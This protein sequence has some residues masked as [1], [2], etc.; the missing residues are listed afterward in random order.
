[1]A[2]GVAVVVAQLLVAALAAQ[3]LHPEEFGAYATL[4][5]WS[6]TLQPFYVLGALSI[7]PLWLGQHRGSRQ[8]IRLLFGLT[9]SVGV[10]LLLVAWMAPTGVLRML[11]GHSAFD[12]HLAAA[13][14]LLF[15]G[16]SWFV[17]GLDSYRGMG[18]LRGHARWTITIL[19]LC[20]VL[21]IGLAPTLAWEA[22][23]MGGV[24]LLAG[25]VMAGHLWGVLPVTPPQHGRPRL[26]DGLRRIPGDLA[27][28][29]LLSFTAFIAGQIHGPRV[30]GWF[31]WTAIMITTTGTIVSSL[32]R[33]ATRYAAGVSRLGRPA[34]AQRRAGSILRPLRRQGRWGVVVGT[35][36][37]IGWG[38]VGPRSEWPIWGAVVL[39]WASLPAYLHQLVARRF[40]D[41]LDERPLVLRPSAWAAVLA[42]GSYSVG[43]VAGAPLLGAAIGVYAGFQLMA[44]GMEH[45]ARGEDVPFPWMRPA[46]GFRALS[47]WR[48]RHAD[49]DTLIDW[50]RPLH[51]D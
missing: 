21:T 42:C 30:A 19:A 1:M 36:L 49:S 31:A 44:H 29:F 25:L 20:P 45:L 12:R 9:G 13:A 2:S 4:R 48:A 39:C 32:T 38:S 11:V 47:P 50:L 28:P 7:L 3:R 24:S 27:V 5:R 17:L 8:L 43:S 18:W 40:V 26:V 6:V 46:W 34:L 41:G 51:R 23:A 14:A 15:W 35:G 37:L 22:A 33:Q 10:A 16:Q